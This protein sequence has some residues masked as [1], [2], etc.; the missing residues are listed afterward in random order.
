[1]AES[2]A[3]EVISLPVF[4]ELTSEEQQ[5]VVEAIMDFDRSPAALNKEQRIRRSVTCHQPTI[6]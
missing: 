2:L 6:A 1:V 5:T 3:D 4:P